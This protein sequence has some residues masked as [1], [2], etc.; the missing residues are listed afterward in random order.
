MIDFRYHLVSLISV[1]LALA[2]GIVLGAGPLRENLG[3]QLAGQV[4]QLRT[5]KDQLRTQSDELAT[6]NDQLGSFALSRSARSWSPAP[7]PGSRSPSSRTT[8][9]RDPTPIDSS[10][11][12]RTPAPPQA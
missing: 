6:R 12:S 8:P 2:V 10:P 3:D 7:S 1:F 9:R 4:E 11:C 5:E